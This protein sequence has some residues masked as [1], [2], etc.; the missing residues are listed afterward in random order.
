MSQTKVEAPF[1]EGGGGTNF[2]NLIIN[3]DMKIAQRA[4]S[5]TTAVNGSYQTLDRWKFYISGGGAYT[6][7]Q[8]ALSLTDQATTGQTKTLDIQCTTADGTVAAGDYAFIMHVIEAQNCQHFKFGTSSAVDLTLQFYV[9]S[10]LTGTTCGFMSKEDS[11]YCQAPFEFTINSANTWEK[12]VVTIPANDV[13][14]ASSSVVN[15]DNGAGVTV[16]FNLVMG[17]NYDNGTNLAW[18]TGG[19]S[20]ATTN[21]LNFLSSTD[22]DLFIT[23]VQLEVGNDA[24]DFEVLP[25]D[26]S[27]ERCRR[28]LQRIDASGTDYGSFGS[29]SNANATSCIFGKQ[30]SPVMC[31]TPTLATT[32]TAANYSTYNPNQGVDAC[33]SVPALNGGGATKEQCRLEF[34]SSGN[35]VAGEAGECLGSNNVAA[36][37]MFH[38]DI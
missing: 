10:N 8:T 5:A 14:K 21:Q 25:H 7:A 30:F 16:A 18:E 15:D 38:A 4:T 28:Y 13:I 2:K 9:K 29:G 33:T 11:T 27:L 3:G 34:I 12:K 36:Y 26:V 37:L 22:N 1:V 19:A 32:G 31:K 24:S 35:L 20:Y 23:G 6:S 17:G